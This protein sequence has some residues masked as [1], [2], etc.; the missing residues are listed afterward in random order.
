MAL[1]AGLT[2]GLRTTRIERPMSP[3]ALW[4]RRLGAFS[5]VLLVTVAVG[6]RFG[7]VATAD[8]F[9][10]SVVVM[11]IAACGL[12][13]GLIAHRRYW[14]WGDR[15]G[16]HIFWGIFWSLATL[17]PFLVI[18]YWYVTYPRLTDISTDL[19]SPPAMA[20]AAGLRGAGMN[21][22]VAPTPES[23]ILQAESYPLIEG[24]RYELPVD[25]VHAAVDVILAGRGWQ[26]TASRD[27]VGMPFETSIEAVARSP[28]LGFPADVAIRLTDEGPS[29]F[30][31]MR[32]VSRYGRHD[33]GENAARIVNFLSELDAAMS[34]QVGVVP[35]GQAEEA[36]TPS[37]EEEGLAP[38]VDVPAPQPRPDD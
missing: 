25:R 15:G 24:R 31:D 34:S 38:D 32:S 30:V 13:A 2:T 20:E 5:F 18:G 6:H 36:E 21:P 8:L 28:L 37:G 27:S 7:F 4:S 23:I 33:L 29:T 3:G 17:V 9:N 16:R 11:A 26:V 10:L 35:A 12:V 14:Y 22:I 19:E 1:G